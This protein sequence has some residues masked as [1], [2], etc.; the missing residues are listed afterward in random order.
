MSSPTYVDRPLD[1]TIWN[2]LNDFDVVMLAQASMAPVA[3]LVGDL[4]IPVL[5]SPRLAVMRALEL[6]GD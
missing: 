3:D 2:A 5:S 1:A 4:S 6:A